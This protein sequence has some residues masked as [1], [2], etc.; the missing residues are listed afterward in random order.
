MKA[1]HEH[2]Q[3]KCLKCGHNFKSVSPFNRFCPRCKYR[4]IPGCYGTYTVHSPVSC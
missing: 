3:K 2:T 4:R 1:Q